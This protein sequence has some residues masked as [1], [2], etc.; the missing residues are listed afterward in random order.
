[1]PE[2]T[3][4]PVIFISTKPL[5]EG[6]VDNLAKDVIGIISKPFD[7]VAISGQIKS[8]WRNSQLEL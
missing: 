3:K 6:L 5:T 2:F 1:M 8:L 7:P 4:T